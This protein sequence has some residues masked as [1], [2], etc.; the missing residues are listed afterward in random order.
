MEANLQAHVA[1]FLSGKKTASNLDTIENLK[2]RPALFAGYRDLTQ[3]RYDFPLILI[4]DP[5]NGNYVESLSGLIDGILDKIARGSNGDRLRKHVLRLEKKIRALSAGKSVPLS[6][7][8]EQAAKVLVKEDKQIQDSLSL[9]HA[10]LKVDGKI[11]DCDGEMPSQLLGHAWTLT[12]RQRA[13][14]FAETANWLIL[15]LSDILQADIANSNTGR[16]AAYLKK[17][18]GSGPMDS[19][20]FDTMSRILCKSVPKENLT[21]S[22]RQR[23]EKLLSVL[24]NQKFFPLSAANNHK[25]YNFTFDSCVGA[26]KAYRER[27]SEAIELSKALAVADLVVRGEYSEA[28]HDR[29]FESFGEDGIDPRDMVMFPDYLVRLHADKLPGAELSA[30]TEIMSLNLPVKILVQTDDV[31]EESPISNGHLAFAL[32]SRQLARM[33]LGMAGVFVMQSP[34]STLYRLRDKILCGLN[35]SGPAL[36][37]VFSGVVGGNHPV[38]P[39]LLG[40]AALE[41]RVFPVFTM[42]PAGT[43]WASR[44]SLE[45]NPQ[46]E[47][48]WPIHKVAFEDKEYQAVSAD[49]PFTLIDFVACHPRYSKF[50][51]VI[52]QADWDS[53][54]TDAGEVIARDKWGGSIDRINSIPSLLMVSPNDK[55]HK[56]IVSEKIVREAR[57]CLTMWNS[58]QELGGVNNSHAEK[59][60]VIEKA[61]WEES[62]KALVTA[63]V[64]SDAAEPAAVPP[65]P[66]DAVP[67]AEVE[68]EK[69]S[70]EAYIETPRCASCN[71]CIQINNK[72]FAYDANKQASIANI[73]AGTY[74][75]LVEA[76]EN[77]QVAIIHPGKPNNPHE[78]GLEE[79]LKRAEAFM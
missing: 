70:D 43:D 59:L 78:P 22:Q 63:D 11:V 68:A 65:V 41:S 33:A 42:D 29:L 46:P 35:A 49:V 72:M 27:L 7:L 50:F 62:H 12:Q 14:V 67:V 53:T 10:N 36:F 66:N 31:I 73:K 40:A 54:L 64:T 25:L 74:A 51:A 77:C 69:S 45:F 5:D 21:K 75:Q 44:F 18:F 6:D 37:S 55:L 71:E 79:L 32:R 30:L 52:P 4:D 28:K 76:A 3:L 9:A 13:R 20:N 1:F 23:V 38:P 24:K 2:L 26:V 19:F 16:S 47:L 8:W 48:D 56:V 57:R 60:L 58:L 39:Y 61:A 15:K 17:S 34:A